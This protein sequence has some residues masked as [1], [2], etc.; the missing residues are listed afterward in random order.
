MH[1][2]EATR[3]RH[4]ELGFFEGWNLCIDQLEALA[5]QLR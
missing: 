2:D 3:A 4:E 1:P 5:R